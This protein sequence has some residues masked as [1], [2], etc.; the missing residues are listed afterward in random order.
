M[1]KG[2]TV[3]ADEL[4]DECLCGKVGIH[5]PHEVVWDCGQY[6]FYYC[7]RCKQEIKV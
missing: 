6:D 4:E 1:C 2:V 7:K 5:P 3:V